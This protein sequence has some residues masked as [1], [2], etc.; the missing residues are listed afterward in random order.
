MENK[1][2]DLNEQLL[3][4]S[5]AGVAESRSWS[6]IIILTVSSA[7]SSWAGTE[8]SPNCSMSSCKGARC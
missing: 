6:T 4:E 3:E 7:V 1:D 2:F 5:N 8:A